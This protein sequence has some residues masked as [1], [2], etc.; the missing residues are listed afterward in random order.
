MSRV[1]TRC[2]ESG[3]STQNKTSNTYPFPLHVRARHRG[4]G[5]TGAPAGASFD[6]HRGNARGGL[7]SVGT[8]LA[9]KLLL[10]FA[11]V[12]IVRKQNCKNPFPFLGLS[13]QNAHLPSALGLFATRD[14][15]HGTYGSLDFSLRC[16]RTRHKRPGTRPHAAFRVSPLGGSPDDGRPSHRFCETRCNRDADLVRPGRV[17]PPAPSCGHFRRRSRMLFVSFSRRPRGGAT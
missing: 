2:V 3:P 8:N 13:L 16:V 10:F 14:T 7:G 12:K 4:V 15:R 5:D 11:E 1:D 9:T 17:G 6:A